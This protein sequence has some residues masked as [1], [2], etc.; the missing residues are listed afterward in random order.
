[1]TG[2][3]ENM[4]SIKA[5]ARDWVMRRSLEAPTPSAEQQF[6][7]W[8]NADPRH[9]ASYRRFEEIWN[10]SAGLQ[11]LADL[12]PLDQEGFGARIQRARAAAVAIIRR[13]AGIAAGVA[14]TAL[15]LLMAFNFSG[16][17]APPPTLTQAYSTQI[18]ELRDIA[19]ADG[20]QLTLGA[21]SD[22]AVSFTADERLVELAAGEAFFAVAQDPGRSFIVLAGGTRVRVTGTQF[23]V[24]RGER[25]VRI[26]VLEGAVEVSQA[27]GAAQ[28]ATDER[29]RVLTAGQQVIAALDGTVTAALDL[30]RFQPGA[31]RQGRLVYVDTA[32]GEVIADAN[33][34]SERPI[35]LAGRDIS[36]LLVSA[37]FRTDQIDQMIN[38]LTGILPI[39][40][41]RSQ[42]HRIVLRPRR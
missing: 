42:P 22:I 21:R 2:K 8:I 29:A 38:S 12:A 16:V 6:E 41:D 18:A 7:A 37:S 33:R 31:W 19:L 27:T 1:M 36:D 9:G 30:G 39:E 24:R 13:P 26:A 10:D 15:V 34:Y 35:E 5:A 11:E 14:V 3:A 28:P 17:I 20:S 25:Q 23:D 32:L 40:A 4:A